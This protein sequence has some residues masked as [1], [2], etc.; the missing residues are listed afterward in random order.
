MIC[1]KEQIF[2]KKCLIKCLAQAMIKR[3]SSNILENISSSSIHNDQ[4]QEE[5]SSVQKKKVKSAS[6]EKQDGTVSQTGVSGF[7]R[8]KV[9]LAEEDDCFTSSSEDDNDDDDTGDEYDQE[10]LLEFQKLISKHMK[11]QKR[12]GALLDFDPFDTKVFATT[13]NW[14][15]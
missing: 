5:Q 14:M 9:I 13:R 2:F 7:G 11:L 10:L 12:H 6:L 8:T 3:S 4:D 1:L 15:Q